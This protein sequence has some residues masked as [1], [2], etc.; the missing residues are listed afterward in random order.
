MMSPPLVCFPWS[1][2]VKSSAMGLLPCIRNCQWPSSHLKGSPLCQPGCEGSQSQIPFFPS[3]FLD[4]SW[5]QLCSFGVPPKHRHYDKNRPARDSPGNCPNNEGEGAG[6]S[7]EILQ[8]MME[9]QH[10]QKKRTKEAK[11]GR[12]GLGLQLSSRIFW[13]GQWQVL[14]PKAPSRGD[15][16]PTG[17]A[18]HRFPLK[19]LLLAET[20][21]RK[22]ELHADMVRDSEGRQLG[23]SVHNMSQ[24]GRSKW[25]I[26]K[27]TQ[28]DKPQ[29]TWNAY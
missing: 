7:R 27:A 14:K 20:I 15:A 25:C 17:T 10:S 21:P 26:F 28:T 22:H 23:P 11:W 13:P 24:S 19:E 6:K 8:T 12:K 16:H 1:S 18:L 3:A 4:H 2:H 29:L 5:Y 9:V